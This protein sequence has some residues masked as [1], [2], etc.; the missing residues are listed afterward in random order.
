MVKY[1]MNEQLLTWIL[2]LFSALFTFWFKDALDRKKLHSLNKNQK[3][4]KTYSILNRLRGSLC[5]KIVICREL[6]KNK[7]F[8]YMSLLEKNP[9]ET[10]SLM[11]ELELLIVENFD[12]LNELLFAYQKAI[13]QL[14]VMLLGIMS[15]S[16]VMEQN[17]FQK[18]IKEY[19]E[20]NLRTNSTLQQA[21]KS[22]YINKR[23]NVWDVCNKIKSCFLIFFKKPNK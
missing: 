7:N 19:N 12:N 11:D 23:I 22:Q 3:A 14:Q 2:T 18:L 1:S 5:M 21:L 20:D 17:E 8:N 16:I 9:D 15:G 13:S 10:S 6:L 4:I